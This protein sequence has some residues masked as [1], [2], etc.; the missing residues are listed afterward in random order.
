MRIIISD[1]NRIWTPDHPALK[2]FAEIIIVVCM[3]GQPMTDEY[4]CF[5][6]E[7]RGS[8]L[9]MTLGKD[10]A[11]YRALE[12]KADELVRMLHY[13]DDI[14]FLTDGE[15]E[16]LY[17]FM[18][19]REKN[20]W[21]YLHLVSMSPWIF[22]TKR[23]KEYHKAALSDLSEVSSLLWLNGDSIISEIDPKSTLSELYKETQRRF[24]DLLPRILYQIQERDWGR[25]YFDFNSM[26]YLPVE[27]GGDLTD[28]A[29][30]AQEIDSSM[31]EASVRYSTLGMLLPNEYPSRDEWTFEEVEALIPR[32][33]GKKI[34]NYL[35][36][37]RMRL[38]EANNIVFESPECP[39]M[40]P[41]AG[42]C[43][44]CEEE[45]A[46]LRAEMEKIV[47]DKRVYPQELL[48][49]WEAF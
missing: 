21:N 17:P 15:P 43:A 12:A 13:H 47:M 42:T 18:I 31:I 37:L 38:A 7:H 22:E 49:E 48:T 45:A 29:L 46:Y 4:Q 44:K 35:R 40:G 23:R 26:C 11:K 8:G 5:V 6:T 3:N 2:P 1:A 41:C 34:C 36:E 32:I 24:G 33:D 16:S 20:E 10:A 14:V 19:I 28:H 39:S 25:A 30:A 27:E 9:G